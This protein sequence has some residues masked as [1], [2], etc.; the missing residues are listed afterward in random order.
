[1]MP[2]APSRLA[3]RGGA[4]FEGAADRSRTSM[5]TRFDRL[6]VA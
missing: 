2:D 6:R 1:M 5:R 3:E 4:L